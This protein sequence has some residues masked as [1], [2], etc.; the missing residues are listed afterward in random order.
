M[1][2]TPHLVVIALCWALSIAI[3]GGI[4]PWIR[5]ARVPVA[6]AMRAG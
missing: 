2:V 4:L 3:L 5:A 6:T 1:A